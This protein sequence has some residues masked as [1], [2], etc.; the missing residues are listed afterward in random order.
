MTAQNPSPINIFFARVPNVVA[1]NPDLCHPGFVTSMRQSLS[2]WSQR[3]RSYHFR[4][5][6]S[7]VTTCLLSATLSANLACA[8]DPV[9]Y[10]PEHT[11]P[12]KE[13]FSMQ[14]QGKE[15]TYVVYN[16][17]SYLLTT[18]KDRSD[19]SFLHN[20]D[21]V[22]AVKLGRVDNGRVTFYNF[23]NINSYGPMELWRTRIDGD[24]LYVFGHFTYDNNNGNFSIVAA[25]IAPSDQQIIDQRMSLIPPADFAGRISAAQWAREMGNVQ[26]NR[27]FWLV[28][29]DNIISRVVDDAVAQAESKKD[30]AMILKAMGWCQDLLRDIP[31]AAR[32]GSAPWIRE[33]GGSGADDV[34]KYMRRWD[35]EFY[36]GQWR[37]RSEALSLEYH[38]RFAAIGWR[39]AEG[40]YKLGRWADANA[41][42]LPRSRELSYNAYQ[43]GFRANSNHNGIRRELGMEP[44]KENGSTGQ[45]GE[46]RDTLTGII[47]PTPPNWQRTENPIAG[48][49]TWIDPNSDTAYIT[50]RILRNNEIADFKVLWAQQLQNVQIKNDF[51]SVS[52][53]DLTLTNGKARIVR[54][55]YREGRYQRSASML[56][57]YNPKNSAALRLDANGSDTENDAVYKQLTA[58]FGQVVLPDAAQ[59]K[60]DATQTKPAAPGTTNIPAAQAPV[61]NSSGNS[62]TNNNEND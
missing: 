42:V 10:A 56:V 6:F 18:P 2:S 16:G 1:T 31:R 12:W 8:A 22:V 11:K 5:Y 41:E 13:T 34:A 50:A 27:E 20:K 17:N 29:A 32:I 45:Q 24:N 35:L 44:A 55:T 54:F 61:P 47:I 40:Y 62:N 38:D 60:P 15:R 59:T 3:M 43:A 51:A 58:V 36:K 25:E 4:S 53:T 23:T 33:S 9:Q 46:F 57:A 28:A 52:E 21:I 37:P 49:A 26:G 7:V 39:D 14:L 30:V 19:L 48:D